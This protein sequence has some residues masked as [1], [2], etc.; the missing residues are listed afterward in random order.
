MV[1]Y[2]VRQN[3]DTNETDFILPTS[4]FKEDKNTITDDKQNT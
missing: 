1:I 3:I 4:N 2:K